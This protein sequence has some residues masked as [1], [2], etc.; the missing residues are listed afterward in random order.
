MTS[1]TIGETRVVVGG[2][3]RIYR[4]V[5]SAHEV[6][7]VAGD[8]RP[9]FTFG[10]RGSAL[11]R[12]NEPT[13]VVEVQATFDASSSGRQES[14]L[15]VADR[16]NHQIQLFAVD[17][18]AMTT[19]DPWQGRGRSLDAPADAGRPFFR[20]QPLPQLVLPWRLDWRAPFLDVETSRG[21]VVS[22]HLDRALL[23]DFR[24]WIEQAPASTLS[25][26]LDYFASPARRRDI[27]PECLHSIA[28]RVGEPHG[29]AASR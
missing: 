26:A 5:P 29:K 7:V 19:I 4:C 25:K 20:L 11:G 13:D 15:A 9:L 22:V 21:T 16:G 3:V 2:H 28:H 18:T 17:G 1:R 27:P 12:L 6:E 14:L 10:G 24:T 8:G 23:P